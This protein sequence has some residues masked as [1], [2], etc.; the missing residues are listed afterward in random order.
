MLLL[1]I[2]GHENGMSIME[3]GDPLVLLIGLPAI[4]VGLVLGRLIRWEDALLR[5][6]RNRGTVVRK[7]PFVSLIYPNL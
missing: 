3:A 5:L 1:Q 2:V 6:I 4:P 7:F